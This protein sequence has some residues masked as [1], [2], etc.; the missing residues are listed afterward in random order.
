M[1]DYDDTLTGDNP[2]RIT[3]EG[4]GT[5]SYN[6]S[7]IGKVNIF[8]GSGLERYAVDENNLVWKFGGGDAW[9]LIAGNNSGTGAGA[10]LWKNHILVASANRVDAYNLGTK[11]W[12]KNLTGSNWTGSAH[13]MHIG[14]DDRVYIADGNLL[15]RISEVDGQT[16]D[17]ANSGTYSASNNVLDLPSNE[18]ITSIVTLGVDL[19]LG[20]NNSKLYRWDRV[21]SSFYNPLRVEAGSIDAMVVLNNLIYIF[22]SGTTTNWG[23]IYVSDGNSIEKIAEIPRYLVGEIRTGNSPTFSPTSVYIKDAKIYFTIGGQGDIGGSGRPAAQFAGVWSLNTKGVLNFEHEVSTG[24]VG[25]N[26]ISFGGSDANYLSY[27]ISSNNYVDDIKTTRYTSYKAFIETPLIRIGTFNQPNTI[28]Q[29]DVYFAE[30]L[31]V[32]GEGIRLKVRDDRSATY[33]TIGEATYANNGGIQKYSFDYLYEGENIQLKAELTT[34]GDSSA[35][36]ELM[37]IRL[38]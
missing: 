9:G 38:R 31:A 24:E 26:G 21:S 23:K 2:L 19:V 30:P 4:T 1:T 3:N 34:G 11:V 13:Y 33:T 5:H 35:T 32:T 7:T 37:E 18:S 29:F 20:T 17:A 22:P 12:T 14:A 10:I 36:P 27:S 6:V 28:R 15:A 16:F 25:Q 8:L